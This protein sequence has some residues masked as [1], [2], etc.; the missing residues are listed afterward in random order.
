MGALKRTRYKE[1]R[2]ADV[3]RK[4]LAKTTGLPL[5]FHVRDLVGLGMIRELDTPSGMF[6][7]LPTDAR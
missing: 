7:R 5:S 3:E 2:H 6:L 4:K 1:M